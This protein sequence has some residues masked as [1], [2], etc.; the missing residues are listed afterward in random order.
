MEWS[1]D[2]RWFPELLFAGERSMVLGVENMKYISS[3]LLSFVVSACSFASE[4]IT[5]EATVLSTKIYLISQSGKCI[6]KQNSSKTILAPKPPCFFLRKLDKKPQYFSYKDVNIDAVLIVTGS[7]VSDEVRKDWGLPKDAICGMVSQG[8][9]IKT[10]K[11]SVTKNVLEGGVLC[12]DIGS[13]EKNFWYFAH[14]E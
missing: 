10:G 9:L 11:V 14:N 3:V 2:E 1:G 8:V 5:D 7:P 12:K 4:R 13:D 6:L